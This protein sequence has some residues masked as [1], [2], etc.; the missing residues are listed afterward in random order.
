MDRRSQQFRYEPTGGLGADEAPNLA[1]IANI[2]ESAYR[3]TDGLAPFHH[4][5]TAPPHPKGY[6][7]TAHSMRMHMS[8]VLS[9]LHNQHLS[10]EALRDLEGRGWCRG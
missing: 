1:T 5:N 3:L 7:R 10:N 2:E 8:S 4:S 9:H 6:D